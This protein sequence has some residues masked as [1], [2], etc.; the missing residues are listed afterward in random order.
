MKKNGALI[1]GLDRI[2]HEMEN[3]IT[4]Q[5]NQQNLKVMKPVL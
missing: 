3:D 1:G 2:L 4:F 5:L